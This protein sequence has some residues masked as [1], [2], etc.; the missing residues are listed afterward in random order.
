MQHTQEGSKGKS[1]QRGRLCLLTA[2]VAAPLPLS[3]EVKCYVGPTIQTNTHSG[4]G[5]VAQVYNPSTQEA[6]A[7]ESQFPGR[8]ELLS[9]TLS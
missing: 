9:E 6:E 5:M 1:H 8:A 2:A 3:S 4:P 7:R